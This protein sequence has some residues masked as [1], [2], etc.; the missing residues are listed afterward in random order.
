M[1]HPS[2]PGTHFFHEGVQHGLVWMRGH[3]FNR[4]VTPIPNG[5]TNSEHG[6]GMGSVGSK[7]HA[8]NPAL[9]DD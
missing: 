1:I 9:D 5:A 4:A 3:D 7:T 6:G 2:W 8:L